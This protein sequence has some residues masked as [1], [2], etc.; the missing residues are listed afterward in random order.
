M[1][2]LVLLSANPLR[3]ADQRRYENAG[4]SILTGPDITKFED[5]VRGWKQD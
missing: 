3:S 4:I 1:V 5:V 2:R